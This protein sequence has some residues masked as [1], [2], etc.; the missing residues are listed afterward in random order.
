MTSRATRWIVLSAASAVT[1]MVVV[2][3]INRC[4][5]S[6]ADAQADPPADTPADTPAESPERRGPRAAV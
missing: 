6:A 5:C 2:W 1:A 3:L 4:A